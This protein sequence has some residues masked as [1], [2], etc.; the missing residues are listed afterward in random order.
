MHINGITIYSDSEIALAWMN[1]K[2]DVKTT[3]RAISSVAYALRWLER[4]TKRI[5]PDLRKKFRG[6]Y[7][8]RYHYSCD[9][10]TVPEYEGTFKLL[11]R[12]QQQ[13]HVE[14]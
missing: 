11:L 6:I 4:I 12:M 14:G 10:I 13:A 9:F 1:P 7:E 3:R 8:L 5:N 2:L